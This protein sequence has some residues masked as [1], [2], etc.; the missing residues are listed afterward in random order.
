MQGLVNRFHVDAGQDVLERLRLTVHGMVDRWLLRREGEGQEHE[1]Y[2]H[3]LEEVD[4]QHG[5]SDQF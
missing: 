4:S 3:D 5:G 1:R 2:E